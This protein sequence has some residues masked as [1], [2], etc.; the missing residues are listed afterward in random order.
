MDAMGRRAEDAELLGRVGGIRPELDIGVDNQLTNIC[1]AAN[2]IR[3]GIGGVGREEPWRCI[4]VP[5]DD[6]AAGKLC[7]GIVEGRPPIAPMVNNGWIVNVADP[8]R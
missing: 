4:V 6:F 1:Q 5:A 8:N 2:R 7:E 3:C